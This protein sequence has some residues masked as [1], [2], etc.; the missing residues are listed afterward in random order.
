MDEPQGRPDLYQGLTLQYWLKKWLPDPSP[1]ALDEL[2]LAQLHSLAS[3]LT[4][5]SLRKRIAD[6]IGHAF[7]E[8]FGGKL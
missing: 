3:S 1:D 4:D 6:P 8:R 5:D 2:I 7:D